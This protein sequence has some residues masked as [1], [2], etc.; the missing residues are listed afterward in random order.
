MDLKKIKEIIDHKIY[1]DQTK[2]RLIIQHLATDESVIPDV[3]RILTLER[4]TKKQLIQDMN[5]ELS[6]ADVHIQHP[7]LAS[8][9]YG[10]K[11]SDQKLNEQKAKEFVLNHITGFYIKYKGIITHCFNKQI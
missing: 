6:R 7:T 1:D 5:L 9:E 3:L 8:G 4:E 2:E 11:K 10:N